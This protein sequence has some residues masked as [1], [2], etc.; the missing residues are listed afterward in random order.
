MIKPI[1][2]PLHFMGQHIGTVI[3]E[4]A[5][6]AA[7]NRQT[8]RVA[9][10]NGKTVYPAKGDYG[11]VRYLHSYL[12][13]GGS[14]SFQTI[15]SRI[16]DHRDYPVNDGLLADHQTKVEIH[17]SEG[18]DEFIR[19]FNKGDNRTNTYKDHL[20]TFDFEVAMQYLCRAVR[21]AAFD[22]IAKVA[23]RDDIDVHVS[24]NISEEMAIAG[25][26]LPQPRYPMYREWTVNPMS[27]QGPCVRAK[28]PV[29][30]YCSENPQCGTIN[31]ALA[32]ALLRH[33]EHTPVLPQ[34]INYVVDTNDG[35]PIVAV[36]KAFCHAEK[37]RVVEA[38]HVRVSAKYSQIELEI[39]L[40]SPN[41]LQIERIDADYV[42]GQYPNFNI[43]GGREKFLLT[44]KHL[45]DNYDANALVN[46][47]ANRMSSFAFMTSTRDEV[48]TEL[49]KVLTGQEAASEVF[50]LDV[51]E[52]VTGRLLRHEEPIAPGAEVRNG[53]FILR[54]S[55]Q[56]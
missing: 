33:S 10:R 18:E 40:A 56:N 55:P 17:L 41:D 48:K 39:V 35:L 1:E 28:S 21:N 9:S 12:D 54:F 15:P 27:S 3:G 38:S 53:D 47:I 51:L 42:G 11:Q 30:L 50:M 26:P 34:Q 31:G 52:S 24:S 29:A 6:D 19:L 2:H 13:Y 20:E 22:V 23:Q 32:D 7:Q 5:D 8:V 49:H 44:G 25:F 37:G 45:D 4:V 43:V 14:H 16:E 36:R 46:T